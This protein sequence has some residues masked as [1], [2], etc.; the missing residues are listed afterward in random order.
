M[1][2]PLVNKVADSGLVSLDPAEF[3]P[4]ET[5]KMFDLKD[6]L[7]MGLILKE[8]DFHSDLFELIPR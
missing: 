7:F 1:N 2:E 5:I 3:Y 8:K 6:H 4:T